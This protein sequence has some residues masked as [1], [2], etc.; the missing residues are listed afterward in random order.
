MPTKFMRNYLIKI[1]PENQEQLLI[2]DVLWYENKDKNLSEWQVPNLL[3]INLD[4]NRNTFASTNE[5]HI[6][7][8]NLNPAHRQR[9]FHDKYRADKIDYIDVYAGYGSNLALVFRGKILQTYSYKQGQNMITDIQ[10]ID[11]GFL[12]YYKDGRKVNYSNMTLEAGT[13]KREAVQRIISDMESG[14]QVGGLGSING[15]F[16]TPVTFIGDSFTL[17]DEITGGHVFVDLG[18]VNVL[19]NK[20]GLKIGSIPI[21]SAETGM[22]GT[23]MRRD[24]QLEV[25]TLFEPSIQVGQLVEIQSLTGVQEYN[26]TFKVIGVHHSGTISS[27]ECGKLTTRFNLFVGTLLP[28]TD[29]TLVEYMNK[30][31]ALSEV[32]NLDVTQVNGQAP[33][34]CIDVFRFIKQNGK[35]PN[36]YIPDTTI[37]WSTVIKQGSPSLAIITNLY[38]VSRNV[39]SAVKAKYGNVN[40]QIS[41]GYRTPQKNSTVG[42]SSKSLHLSGSALDITAIG[43]LS[44]DKIFAFF[45]NQSWAREVL[46]ESGCVHVGIN[47]KKRTIGRWSKSGGFVPINV[48]RDV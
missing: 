19:A 10:A 47:K 9:L 29:I 43:R 17:L 36:T 42:G 45:A 31:Q 33:S 24:A 20:E 7:I 26:G 3:T 11:L 18:K 28:N 21:I 40:I 37:K 39:S 15:T 38:N 5:A 48:V 32:E 12:S 41:S 6:Q 2:G 1:V 27:A 35:A 4:I 13:S 44:K 46:I 23:P 30:M 16:Q 22:L 34:A 8:L 14:T 25:D